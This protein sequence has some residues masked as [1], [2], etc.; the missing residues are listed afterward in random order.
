MLLHIFD[1]S[2]RE[3]KQVWIQNTHTTIPTQTLSNGIYICKLAGSNE[4]QK[5]VIIK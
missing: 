5:L 1:I 4:T 3:V 2:G